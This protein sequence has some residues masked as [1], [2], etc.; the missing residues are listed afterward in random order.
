MYKYVLFTDNATKT[1]ILYEV[2]CTAD[3]TFLVDQQN[4]F[5]IVQLKEP[6]AKHR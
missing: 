1:E 4:K 5:T 3:S 2:D 6:I